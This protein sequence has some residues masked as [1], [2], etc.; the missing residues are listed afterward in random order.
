MCGV[1]G[2][3]PTFGRVPLTGH[4]PDLPGTTRFDRWLSV[5]G[6][7]ARSAEDLQLAFGIL[8]GP[9]G[10]DVDVPPVS[11]SVSQA[12]SIKSLRF[13]W[14]GALS[15]APVA[16]GIRQAV[17]GLAVQL[18]RAGAPVEETMPNIDFD[19][20]LGVWEQLSAVALGLWLQI[21]GPLGFPSPPDPPPQ[22]TLYDMSL[23]LQKR[24]TFTRK[25]EEL[26]GQWDV[27][28]W[29]VTMTTAFHHC[30]PGTPIDV[31]G[32]QVD[33]DLLD[34]YCRLFSFTGHPVV[35]VPVGRDEQGL[36]VGVQL[37]GKRW[38]DE[39]LLA[40]AQRASEVVQPPDYE[41]LR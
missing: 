39:R 29:P 8:A 2:M 32:Q 36:P 30:E 11:P 12:P 23:I 21:M 5:I 41:S 14:T 25:I 10:V 27:L 33:Y 7:L 22:P 18:E 19:E 20:F 15:S 24:D 9:D 26:F 1:F 28:V 34:L 31:D 4:I 40:I 16:A 38:D 6:P 37:I 17:E 35:V 13:A 3:K